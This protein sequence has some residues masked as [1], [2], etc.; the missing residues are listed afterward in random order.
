MEEAIVVLIF[1]IDGGTSVGFLHSRYCIVKLVYFFHTKNI[2]RKAFCLKK[3]H[4]Q[5]LILHDMAAVSV[6][7]EGID[8]AERNI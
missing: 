2:F 8:K 4:L 5:T 3:L 1:K 7:T 6:G